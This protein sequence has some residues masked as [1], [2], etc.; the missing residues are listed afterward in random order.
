MPSPLPDSPYFI[1]LSRAPDRPI[2]EVWPINLNMPLPRIP[3][4]LLPEDDDVPLELQLALN[5]AYD[6]FGYHLSVNYNNPPE[7]PLPDKWAEWA[8][9]LLQEAGFGSR[10]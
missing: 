5:T 3:I 7:I 4:P 9:N 8:A 1:F 10:E 2:I 6:T